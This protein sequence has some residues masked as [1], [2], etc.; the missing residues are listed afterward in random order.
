MP[1][2]FFHPGAQRGFHPYPNN[3]FQSFPGFLPPAHPL[4]P[5]SHFFPAMPF[6]RSLPPH[7]TQR[8]L[9]IP[10]GDKGRDSAG[11][12]NN[13]DHPHHS[14]TE[15]EEEYTHS[16]EEMDQP[17]NLVSPTRR[18]ES[19]G[20]YDLSH[21]RA[22]SSLS[23][24]QC[25]KEEN[26][27]PLDL[28]V[29][30]RPTA[31]IF[32]RISSPIG[33]SGRK[34]HIF[35]EPNHD[36]ADP[37]PFPYGFP[38][39]RNF[40]SP[41][42]DE[43]QKFLAGNP[44]RYPFFS[45]FFA[46]AQPPFADLYSRNSRIPSF[47]PKPHDEMFDRRMQTAAPPP[48][49]LVHSN[50]PVSSSTYNLPNNAGKLKERYTC[51]F[52]YKVFPRSANL[53]RHLRTHTGEQP[54]KCNVCG[55]SFSISSNLQRH[56]RNIHHKE[57]PFKCPLCDRCFGQQTNLDRHLKKHE[58]EA[59]TTGGADTTEPQNSQNG[60]QTHLKLQKSCIEGL[61]MLVHPLFSWVAL[62][63]PFITWYGFSEHIFKLF[64]L[65]N[66]LNKHRNLAMYRQG[67]FRP[68][69][70]LTDWSEAEVL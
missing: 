42:Q 48:A 19:S 5:P 46:N 15:D 54:Y 49:P 26:E 34:T 40:L 57:K 28:S 69:V 64:C 4:S 35:G 30:A 58:A 65:S 18:S 8:N 33:P 12:T 63:D 51:K 2:N 29:P 13:Q 36:I 66:I 25:R 7:C 62:Y 32:T 20:G 3:F 21:R 22:S 11:S 61:T 59:D 37:T 53:T 9:G 39:P 44:A 38:Q 70:L 41:N 24:E 60:E 10:S 45:A 23:D 52:C 6:P 50:P 17:Y 67:Q 31:P 43:M 16:D 1:H 47:P 56:V 27:K 55:R 14:E 68:T